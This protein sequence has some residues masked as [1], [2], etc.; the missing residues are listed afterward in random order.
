[1]N[2][3]KSASFFADYYSQCKSEGWV[4]CIFNILSECYLALGGTVAY[5]D[6]HN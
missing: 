5:F 3:T 6:C 4:L 2:Q 1:M